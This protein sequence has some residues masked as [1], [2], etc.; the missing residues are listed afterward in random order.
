MDSVQAGSDG[1]AVN[2]PARFDPSERIDLLA[3]DLRTSLDGLTA[4]EADRRLVV[5]G[6]NRLERR[7]GRAWPRELARQFT[8]PFALLLWGAAALAAIA[9]IT[10]VAIAVVIVIV[11]NAG[12]AFVQEIQAERA[13]EALQ[14]YLPHTAKVLRD[15]GPRDRRSA[16][17]SPATCS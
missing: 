13:V 5:F 9:G 17:S 8:H 2:G 11:L 15:G 12:F 7:R 14:S 10:P 3:R 6:P 16:D 4:R 1:S